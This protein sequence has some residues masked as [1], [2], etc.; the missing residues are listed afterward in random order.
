MSLVLFGDKLSAAL[1]SKTL[2]YG[3]FSKRMKPKVNE[4]KL[5][6]SKLRIRVM[7]ANQIGMDQSI[8]VLLP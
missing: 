5:L 1:S 7:A 3:A 8:M 4:M 6:A 2:F